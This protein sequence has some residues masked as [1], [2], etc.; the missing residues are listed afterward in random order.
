MKHRWDTAGWGS[1]PDDRHDVPLDEAWGSIEG[2]GSGDG[3]GWGN[4]HEG[5]TWPSGEGKGAGYGDGCVL[6]TG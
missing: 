5:G 6:W 2:G 4:G 1:A 3:Y